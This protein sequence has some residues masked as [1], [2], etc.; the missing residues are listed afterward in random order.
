MELRG[1]RHPKK[2]PSCS[3]ADG[4]QH[5]QMF[6]RLSSSSSSFCCS[7]SKI[8]I[9][10]CSACSAAECEESCCARGC[11]WPIGAVG[12]PVIVPAI[13]WAK[14]APLPDTASVLARAS[15]TRRVKR[16]DYSVEIEG[17]FKC[18]LVRHVPVAIVLADQPNMHGPM[19]ASIKYGFILSGRRSHPLEMS[20][21]KCAGASSLLQSR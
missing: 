13:D 12:T 1:C 16:M 6:N 3:V 2:K 10:C 7:A 5:R 21:M 20:Q 11:K 17:K 18:D 4:H 9:C 15:V 14:T 19:A 8:D